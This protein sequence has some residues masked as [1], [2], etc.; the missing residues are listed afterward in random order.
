MFF[1]FEECRKAG[2]LTTPPITLSRIKEEL[3]TKASSTSKTI[4]ARLIDKNLVQ[5]GRSKTGR[6]GW[7][8]FSLRQDVFQ[9]LL[10]ETDYKQTTNGAQIDHKEIT[11]RATQRTT[12]DSSSSIDLNKLTTTSELAPE[13]G[14]VDFSAVASIGF[15]LAHVKQ[16]CLLVDQACS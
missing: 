6:G 9:R 4:L 2:E 5:R 15:G 16:L 12:N 1:L 14:R 3:E 8:S 7:M 10:L 11:K 13:W